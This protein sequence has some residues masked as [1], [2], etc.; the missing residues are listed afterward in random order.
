MNEESFDKFQEIQDKLLEI[1]AISSWN[2]RKKL[3]EEE[4][5]LAQQYWVSIF[6]STKWSKEEYDQ[7]RMDRYLALTSLPYTSHLVDNDFEIDSL[8]DHAAVCEIIL[9]NIWKLKT[10]DETAMLPTGNMAPEYFIIGGIPDF[11]LEINRSYAENAYLHKA[12]RYAKIQS[13]CWFTHLLKFSKMKLIE[14]DVKQNT[15]YL[16]YEIE[17]LKPRLLIALGS[18]VRKALSWTN[19]PVTFPIITVSEPEYM[20]RTKHPYEEYGEGIANALNYW[21]ET[22]RDKKDKK[23]KK[24][25]ENAQ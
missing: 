7:K 16:E 12:L 22:E 2:N 1:A 19:I 6:Q 8:Y 18:K 9:R 20:Q 10:I 25:K 11:S 17:M 14:V 23:D 24:E 15:S 3:F 5:Q 4:N 13:E 21:A